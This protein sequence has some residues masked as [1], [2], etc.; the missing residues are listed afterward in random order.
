MKA[1]VIEKHIK[2]N[3][4]R[5]CLR[6]DAPKPKPNKNQVIVDVDS[7]GL[8]FF[9]ILQIQGKYQVK[10]PHPYVLGTEFSGRIAQDSP[11][12]DGCQFE[13][14]D[15]VF[16]AG[17]GSYAEQIAVEHDKLVPVPDNVSLE[18]AAGL[19]ITM[20]TAYASLVNRANLQ[21]GEFCLIHA[22]AGGVGLAAV[23]IAKALGAI[24]IA[25]CSTQDKLD[26][27]KRFGADYGIN[28]SEGEAG[29]WQQKVKD[30]TK[31]HG[32]DVVYDPVGMLV[33]SLKCIAWNGR[34][35]VVGFAAG[36]I[37]KV[38]ANLILLKNISVTGCH[39]GAYLRHEPEAVPV[40]WA[41][42]LS[43]L[44]EGKIRGT[45]YDKLYEGL[46]HVPEGLDLLGSR[47][48]WGKVTVKVNSTR[49][50]KI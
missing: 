9:D 2:P 38:P 30:I 23:Q 17:Q 18:E 27:A 36:S 7:A 39:F 40:I 15:Y 19:F 44:S 26:V 35:V 1:Y 21:P 4:L 14:G 28:Y 34:L 11:L 47:Q 6:S 46:E 37:E 3:E 8:N 12:P 25:C 42:L 10:P 13:R 32:A 29:A 31:G 50:A 41:A 16:G 49:Q 24:V 43:L 20:P 5:G 33:P 22:A 45:V 48:T